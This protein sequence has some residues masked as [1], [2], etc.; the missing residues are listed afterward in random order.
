MVKMMF[1]LTSEVDDHGYVCRSASQDAFVFCLGELENEFQ[2]RI[3]DQG[4]DEDGRLDT[5]TESRFDEEIVWAV[6][7]IEPEYGE[8]ICPQEDIL[9]MVE[10]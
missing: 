8:R 6:S 9:V 2:L 7:V 4:F 5:L 3:V 10:R 1:L